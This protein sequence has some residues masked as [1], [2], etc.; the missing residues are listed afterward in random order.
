MRLWPLGERRCRAQREMW[1]VLLLLMLMELVCVGLWA[2][3]GAGIPLLAA[4]VT[5]LAIVYLVMF[6][7]Q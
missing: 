2:A 7:E 5:G 1:A 6:S 3:T 4:L